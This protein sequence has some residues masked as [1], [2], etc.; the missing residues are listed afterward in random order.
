MAIQ[1]N[2]NVSPYYD[3]FDPNKN[4]YRVLYK[5]GYPI[6]AREL[7][8]Q[9]SIHADQL[10]KIASRILTEGDNVVPGEFIL[11][12]PVA[13]V[14]LSTFTNGAD[15]QEFVGYTL[16]GV[17]SGVVADVTFAVDATE[18]DDPT[19]YVT[20]VSSG[21]TGEYASFLQGEVLES[22]NPNKITASVGINEI[23]KPT[24]SEPMGF[25]ALFRVSEGSYFIDGMAIRNDTQEIVA[26]KYTD[27]FDANLG[28]LVTE[29]IVTA[30]DDASLL[31]NSQGSSNFAAP[32]ADRLK[33]TLTLVS[34]DPA[35]TDPNFVKLASVVQGN[36]LNTPGNTVK[37]DWLYDILA[38]RTYDESG[39]YITSDFPVR[40]MEY[41][42]DDTV[43]GLY[44]ADSNG[45]YPP[46][47]GSGDTENISYDKAN[48]S[49]V[50]S[51]SPGKAYVRGYEIE[52]TNL[53]YMY[54]KKARTTEFRPD[55]LAQIT[56]GYNLTL[57]N[58]Y[59]TPDFQ[60]IS[61]EGTAVA[62]NDVVLYRNYID[63]FVG[64]STDTSGRPKNTGNAPWRT[65][66]ILA[67]GDVGTA[68]TGFTE[69]YKSGK[70]AVVNTANTLQRGDSIGNAKILIANEISPIPAGVIRPRYM[71]PN[72]LV[73]VGDGFY[74]YNSTYKLGIMNSVYFTELSVVSVAGD[75]EGW[76]VGNT[77]EGETTGTIATVEEGSTNSFLVVSGVIGEFLPGEEIVQGNKVVRIFKE[78]E[79]DELLFTDKGASGTTIDLSGE[80]AVTVSAVGVSTTLSGSEIVV[81]S[82]GIELTD[83]GRAKLL[84]FPYPEGSA[85][86]VRL[87][88]LLETVPNG[89]SGY[90]TYRT[91]K[92]SNTLGLAKSFYS[93]L[94]DTNDFSADI[95]AQSTNDAEII[96]VAGGSLFTATAGGIKLTCDNFSGDASEQLKSGDVITFVDD[97]NIT[98]SRIVAFA[99][100]PVGYGETR[101]QAT[102]Y[103]TTPVA[104][105]VTGKTVERIRVKTKGSS[106]ETLIY[107]LP[108]E[109]IST[110]ETDQ[111]ATQI[112][113]QVMREFIVN[114]PS[115]TNTITLTTGR[116]N[117]TFIANESQTSLVIAENVSN[118]TDPNQTEGRALTTSNIDVSQDNGR[119]V[120]YT[121]N[122]TLTSSLKVKVL[123]P[124]F[125]SDAIAKR[126]VDRVDQT[127][128]IA[129]GLAGGDV[130]SLGLADVYSV[131]SATVGGVNVLDNYDFDNGQRDNIYDLSRLILKTGRPAAQGEMTVTLSYF[132][133]TGEGDFFSVDSYTDQAGVGYTQIPT[134]SSSNIV[135]RDR[136]YSKEKNKNTIYLRDVIDFRPVVNTTGSNPSQI[137]AIADG[138]DAQNAINFRGSSNGGNAFVPRIPIIETQF[139]CDLEYYLPRYDSLFLQSNG[140]MAL[141]EGSPSDNPQPH[142]DLSSAIRLYDI[143]LPPYTFELGDIY[144][145]KFNYKVY[146]MRDIAK[147][148]RQVQNIQD[149]VTLS[150]LEQDAINFAVRDAE[151][152]LDRYKNGIVVD[153]F[154]NHANGDTKLDQYRCSI[155]P[156]QSQLRAPFFI[157]QAH[158]ETSVLT[159]E[160][161]N[162]QGYALNNGIVTVNFDNAVIIDQ[163]LATRHVNLQPY[164]VFTYE[165]T[166]ELIPNIDTF[167]SQN[168]LPDL[169]I[170]DNSLYNAMEDLT[171]A[172]N[173]GGF[174]TVWTDWN[175]DGNQITANEETTTINVDT[176]T[177]ENTS[178]GKRVVDVQV[179]DTM[180]TVPVVFVGSN[181]K[182]NTKYYAFFDGIDVTKWCIPGT[183]SGD[184]T[185]GNT[186]YV[187]HDNTAAT[188]G[189]EILSDDFGTITGYFLVPEGRAPLA[190]SNFNISADFWGVEYETDGPTRTFSTGTRI[191]RFTDVESNPN[192]MS[193]VGGICEGNFTS[194]G[195]ILDVEETVVS[196][197]IPEFSTNTQVTDTQTIDLPQSNIIV[198]PNPSPPDPVAQSFSVDSSVANEGLFLTE[199]DVFFRTKDPIQPC[200]VYLVST[201][202]QVPTETII[203]H[204]HV[205]KESNTTLRVQCTNLNGDTTLLAAGTSVVGQTSG[206][207]GVLAADVIFQ[208][209]T[210]N[211]SKNVTNHV[212]NVVI[213][214]Y[215][216]EFVAGET[217]VPAVTPALSDTFVIVKDEYRVN[218]IDL[219]RLGSGYTTA[220]VTFTAPQLPGGT[221][222]TGTVKITNGKVYDITLTD[223][224]SGYTT[225]PSV[226]IVGDGS[227][228]EAQARVDYDLRPAVKM[229]VTVS[230]DASLPTKFKFKAPVF[231]FPDTYYAFVV[232]SG[233][234]LEYT[235]YTAKMGENIIG[236]DT[237]VVKQ[238]TLGSLFMSQNGG[239]WT[240]D[241]TQ[242]MTFTLHCAEFDTNVDAN[243][244]LT[245]KPIRVRNIGTDPI[246][247]S[248]LGSDTSSTIFGENAQI[249]KVYHH[250]HGLAVGD[251][252]ILDGVT[253][254]PGGIPN[255]ELNQLHT[256][257]SVGLDVFTIQVTTPATTI[258]KAGGQSVTCSYGR[259][260]EVINLT[261]G[262]MTFASTNIQ[263]TVRAAGAAGVTGYNGSS[264]YVLNSSTTVGLQSD[265]YFTDAVQVA[266]YLNEANFYRNLGGEKSLVVNST[267][268]ATSKYISP[269][270]DITRTNAT[271]VRNLI[272]N[273]NSIDDIYAS[274][275]RTIT[276]NSDIT[277]AGLTVGGTIEFTHEAILRTVNVLSV[278]N[279]TGKVKIGG[280]FGSLITTTTTFSDATLD[281]AGVRSITTTEN[282][283]FYPE[284]DNRGS[285]YA[286]YISRLFEFENACDGI[287]IKMAAIFYD[288][289]SIRVYYKPRNVGF[290][291]EFA[292]VNWIPF[293]GT[294]YPNGVNQITA[295][296]SA[297]VDPSSITPSSWQELT[298][299]TQDVAKFDAVAIKIVMTSENP[300]LAPLIDD[301][302]MVCSE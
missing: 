66:H 246:E 262:A 78:T 154:N 105:N 292:E 200:E 188:F 84:N 107:Q 183:L 82:T 134:Y 226:T 7:T 176:A 1:K 6:Q 13:Y 104:N 122:Q 97:Q 108:E 99:T 193:L 35:A 67:D 302:R 181:L 54:G 56:Q 80:T 298:W 210:N 260:Y 291:G 91:P 76:V 223:P 112:S 125:V 16:T 89:V 296:S 88:L 118:P 63:G 115:G 232:K 113:Y 281:A 224:G 57:T 64:E 157:D 255:T 243:V 42:N 124:V 289:S 240:E 227:G 123:V 266:N 248:N 192:D 49:Y 259:P 98:V 165:G 261:T 23:S 11:R 242:D 114:A 12:N 133:H 204:T 8:T 279:T 294:G 163:P 272:D 27:R 44:D 187:D 207:A 14:R 39:D 277:A 213:D 158:L 144:I 175:Q 300:A 10:E 131:T 172:M 86:S 182:P 203:P 59:G 75:A 241:Q 145:K 46:I 216:G 156:Q 127:I 225:V 219:T 139:R 61:G 130:I 136:K 235:V 275:T 230:D 170:E 166:L 251:L 117:E 194:S 135:A 208:N 161:R 74:G 71:L 168:Q 267:L 62:F 234:S 21:T 269:V 271:L 77:V 138:V 245:N 263:T 65:Y 288:T 215:D 265:Y 171:A 299:T 273:P 238:P 252:V 211:P 20:Y 153:S 205:T 52:Y 92:I 196:T 111:A 256:V 286:K 178:Y 4:F 101:A 53:L 287:E 19:L 268:T 180:R 199:L 217:I 264:A 220:T 301:M 33:I 28:F 173:E 109:V 285:A 247:Y 189:D 206:A 147:L 34:Q 31:D 228:A 236:T 22:G 202:G 141:I 186:R 142:K 69:V 284:T 258:G 73:D 45:Q 155:D 43:Y 149:A 87:E 257:V 143:F 218:R 249:V 209:A 221:T 5:A 231:I 239:L 126:K 95:S 167:S 250:M 164:S 37:W 25:G 94:A 212:Y 93:P 90:A 119:K 3:D 179:A 116:N 160:D 96:S 177:I 85:Q 81:S 229:G 244:K 201:E 72:E 148:D 191:L 41:W 121:L 100:K 38:R 162:L 283:G 15:I 146:R 50:L 36:I 58:V 140:S 51:V 297:K 29:S 18:T 120:I 174:G 55:T 254:N 30:D 214:N 278:N 233:T 276:F 132:E 137:S 280:R 102:I 129:A 26:S 253:G 198:R 152:G 24:T 17:T 40:P 32:G 184:F 9:Q 169:V 128:T 185:D 282:G 106:R 270:L 295:R 159:E 293:N 47:P 237:R 110:L 68:P 70:G 190:S 151:T 103:L 150:L 83:A 222:A 60:N 48:E 79:V 290:D 197:R 195:V 2:L 274:D